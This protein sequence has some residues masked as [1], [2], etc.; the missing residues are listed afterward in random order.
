MAV[1][2]VWNILPR[3]PRCSSSIREHTAVERMQRIRRLFQ[4]SRS[5]THPLESGGRLNG[6]LF[7]GR[8]KFMQDW[9]RPC[10]AMWSVWCGTYRSTAVS[11]LTARRAVSCCSTLVAKGSVS[12]GS[13]KGPPSIARGICGAANF[14]GKANEQSDNHIHRQLQRYTTHTSY[15]TTTRVDV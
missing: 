5:P 8:A 9:P 2:S 15:T 12:R 6:H 10:Y 13:F 1:S 14:W 4:A 3:V 11:V 7:L